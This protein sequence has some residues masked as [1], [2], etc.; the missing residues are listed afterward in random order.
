MEKQ[1][2]AELL[3]QEF[4][5]IAV[6]KL[7]SVSLYSSLRDSIPD[8][9]LV[10]QEIVKYGQADEA[11]DRFKPYLAQFSVFPILGILGGNVLCIGISER[12]RGI[13]YY[14]DFDF[15]HL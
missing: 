13:V 6:G 1:T 3:W 14:Y 4:L 5:S 10:I 7:V 8:K 11:Y 12:N 2:V 9:Y 15:R